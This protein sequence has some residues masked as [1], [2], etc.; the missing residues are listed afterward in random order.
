MPFKQGL[1][2][3]IAIIG[4]GNILFKDEGLGIYATEY[5]KQ[6]YQFSPNVDLIDGG[7]LGMNLI[8]YYQSYEQVILLDTI[9]VESSTKGKL[10]D[11]AESGAVYSLDSETL[12]GL[13]AYR[14]TAHEV[15]VLQ[16]LELAALTGETAK[17]QVIAMVPEDIQTVAIQLSQTVEQAMP[18][19]IQTTIEYLESLGIEVKAN[20]K[21]VSLIQIEQSYQ[22]RHAPSCA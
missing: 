11:A 20:S 8:H 6:N 1:A 13:G 7:T 4:I 14:K 10:K 19:M 21:P 22:F 18:L 12:Q 17:I 2:A 15:E 5:L 3:N 9:S 16:T